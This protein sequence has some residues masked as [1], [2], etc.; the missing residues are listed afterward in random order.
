MFAQ[1]LLGRDPLE[2]EQIYNDLKRGSAQARS[3]GHR[4]VD[5]AL[6]DIAG[7]LYDAPV[8]QLLGGFRTSLPAYAS[9]YHGDDN[10]GLTRRRRLASSPCGARR[11]AIRRSRSTAGARADRARGRHGPADA[12]ARSATGWT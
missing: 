3:H 2:R 1:Y 10:G 5:I 12:P 9:T 11:W 4:A 7:K 8:S 6:W